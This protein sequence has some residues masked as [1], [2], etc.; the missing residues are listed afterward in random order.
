M[1]GNTQALASIATVGRIEVY[2]CMAEIDETEVSMLNESIES[3]H[4]EVDIHV[5]LDGSDDAEITM[6]E[7]VERE[8]VGVTAGKLDETDGTLILT[9]SEDHIRVSSDSGGLSISYSHNVKRL[10][11][12]FEKYPIQYVIQIKDQLSLVNNKLPYHYNII[13]RDLY[14]QILI[15]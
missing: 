3:D 12:Q 4:R 2:V 9:E 5:E 13:L 1:T 11:A 7:T 6:D 14:D 10:V 15:V 8:E